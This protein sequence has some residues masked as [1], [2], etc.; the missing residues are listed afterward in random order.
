MANAAQI[1]KFSIKDSFFVQ[2][3]VISTPLWYS[4]IANI[5]YRLLLFK[6]VL[7]PEFLIRL[8]VLKLSV[9]N[10]ETIPKT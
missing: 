9:L 5:N 2:L 8:I 6:Y 1:M 7:L 10:F 3:N 4:T